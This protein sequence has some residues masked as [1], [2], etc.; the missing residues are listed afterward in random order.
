MITAVIVTDLAAS[1]TRQ[2]GLPRLTGTVLG[3]TPGAAVHPWLPP[4]AWSAGLGIRTAMFLS[5][6]LRLPEAAKVAGFVRGIVMLDH[7]DHPWSYALY[8]AAEA[9]PGIGMAVLVSL[10]SPL[11]PIDEPTR[12]GP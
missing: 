10:V 7:G 9:G 4:A 6:V 11:A 12:E 5:H 1:R 2:L 3:T 8:R